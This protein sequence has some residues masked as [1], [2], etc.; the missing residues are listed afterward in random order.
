MFTNWGN[1]QTTQSGNDAASSRK[2]SVAVVQYFFA[3]HYAIVL[4]AYLL[5][6]S[7]ETQKLAI[8]HSFH[9]TAAKCLFLLGEIL[10]SLQKPRCF[11]LWCANT[12]T[13][14]KCIWI[15]WGRRQIRLNEIMKSARRWNIAQCTMDNG[16]HFALWDKIRELKL[17][18]EFSTFFSVLFCFC[19]RCL[20][21]KINRVGYAKWKAALS[22]LDFI[23]NGI[24]H[25]CARA[26]RILLPG[27]IYA[28]D[29]IFLGAHFSFG[30]CFS[31]EWMFY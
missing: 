24:E 10:C 21:L 14:H 22:R 12:I 29:S 23:L 30:H 2:C 1:A 27:C 28:V 6:S 3:R 31:S 16:I 8:F 20:P 7:A 5:C 17:A 25:G 18:V 15:V 11:Y 4:Y 9:S 26:R 19:L 13:S